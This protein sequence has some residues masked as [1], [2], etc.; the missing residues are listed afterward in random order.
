MAAFAGDFHL[1][2]NNLIG[3]VRFGNHRQSRT[4]VVQAQAEKKID[5]T[6]PPSAIK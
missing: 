5:I 6:F 3:V 1:L 2:V 4:G